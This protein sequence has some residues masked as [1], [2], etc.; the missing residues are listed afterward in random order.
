MKQ[1]SPRTGEWRRLKKPRNLTAAELDG[2]HR[3]AENEELRLLR[4]LAAQTPCVDK[5]ACA[6]LALSEVGDEL[7]T[8]RLNDLFVSR[9]ALASE[10]AMHAAFGAS[11]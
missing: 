7:R 11:A 8:L 3:V 2:Y 5:A 4:I 1:K 6:S 9:A 10:A